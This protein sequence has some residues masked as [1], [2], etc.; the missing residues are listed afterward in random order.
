MKPIDQLNPWDPAD[1]EVLAAYDAK[2][3][4]IRNADPEYQR[5][6]KNIRILVYALGYMLYPKGP[7]R[8]NEALEWQGRLEYS[9]N[10]TRE[11]VKG[12][13]PFNKDDVFSRVFDQYLSYRL[14]TT[15]AL[16]YQ[17]EIDTLSRVESPMERLILEADE[18][19][20]WAYK[21]GAALYLH[22]Q[23]VAR[24]KCAEPSQGKSQWLI[25]NA[26]LTPAPREGGIKARKDGG[27]PARIAN[28][29]KKYHFVA[30]YW[31]AFVVWA[32]A[33][34]IYP[35]D[36][37]ALVDFVLNADPDQFFAN[38]AAFEQFRKE[39]KVTRQK[40]NSYIKEGLGENIS[41]DIV[42]TPQT[43]IPDLLE[44]YQWA[45]LTEYTTPKRPERKKGF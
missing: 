22:Q 6:K 30:H 10:A 19:A 23:M 35:C 12:E 5:R 33:P 38:A 3:L 29:W 27:E 31:A 2:K 39:V 18:A 43:S 44:P 37:F 4:A 15:E 7:Y 11:I 34:L 40:A 32:K 9:Q 24:S 25:S 21:L 41:G 20:R 8:F 28:Q 13:Y 1:Q 17:Q 36:R 45:A 16:S 42:P 26:P 14:R